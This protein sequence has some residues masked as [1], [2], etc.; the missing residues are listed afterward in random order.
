MIRGRVVEYQDKWKRL[1][2]QFPDF[3]GETD[4]LNTRRQLEACGSRYPGG[5]SPIS[6]Q[7]FLVKL[8]NLTFAYD[9]WGASVTD[10]NL[11]VG[12]EIDMDAEL[13]PFAGSGGGWFIRVT[14]IRIR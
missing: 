4:S 6:N 13:L 1:R 10:Y 3:Y 7:T 5:W 14:G 8:T 11:L 2:L 12:R 9:E